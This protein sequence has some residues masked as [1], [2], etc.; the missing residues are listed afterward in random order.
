M[1]PLQGKMNKGVFSC[2]ECRHE[3]THRKSKFNVVEDILGFA[4]SNIGQMVVWQCKGCGEIYFFH[5]RENDKPYIKAHDIV[6]KYHEYK[7]T[8]KWEFR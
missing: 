1:I 5:L 7:E 8:G 2:F 4:N 3:P 6:V